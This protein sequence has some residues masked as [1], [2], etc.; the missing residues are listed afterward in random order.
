MNLPNDA[1]RLRL[2]RTASVCIAF[3]SLLTP[4]AIAQIGEFLRAIAIAIECRIRRVAFRPQISGS[5]SSNRS[6]T[7]DGQSL[8]DRHIMKAT[9]Q[10]DRLRKFKKAGCRRAA[11]SWL[12]P[13]L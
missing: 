6:A 8:S 12:S 4:S 7:F 5:G 3:L 9:T 13:C 2:F 11:V 1:E 10:P